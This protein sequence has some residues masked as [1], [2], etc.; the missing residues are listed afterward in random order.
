MK[1]NLSIF[2]ALSTV[3]LAGVVFVHAAAGPGTYTTTFPHTENPL[4]ESGRWAG[5]RS[6]GGN[7][8]GDVRT[9]P[10]FA[11]GVDEPT[12]FGDPTAILTGAWG[13]DQTVEGTVRVKTTPTRTCCHE[14]ELRLR[15]TISP[16]SITGYEAY[17]SVTPEFPYCHIARWNGPNA[18]YCNIEPP[19]P[20][21]YAVNGDVL[22]A[23]V[24]GVNPVVITLYKN[25]AQVAQAID[26]GG[27]CEPGG[28]AGPFPTGN[29]GIGFYD[30]HDSKWAD[31]GLSNF[32]ATAH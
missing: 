26:A 10:A 8:W 16:N 32:T 1:T 24:T 7:L 11:F 17:C 12:R 9:T 25:G 30:D 31:F 6:A 28:P 4:S 14:V 13:P 22:K 5:G 15:T 21:A 3:A 20:A 2:A 19:S 27:N 23:T 18:S 29:P